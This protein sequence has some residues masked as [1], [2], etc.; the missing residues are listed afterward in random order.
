MPD[1]GF[2][3]CQL[4]YILT[5]ALIKISFG[6]TLL[7]IATKR[8]HIYYLYTAISIITAYTFVY[9]FWFLSVCNP[10]STDT[11]TGAATTISPKDN[12]FVCPSMGQLKTFIYV[13]GTVLCIEDLIFGVIPYFILKD[14]QLFLS[15]KLGI[16]IF[17]AISST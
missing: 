4:L 13:H 16:G 8:A 9:F 14:V 1:Q 12:D 17:M 3:I 15:I 11:S 7:S 5:T 2:F 6:M 10:N